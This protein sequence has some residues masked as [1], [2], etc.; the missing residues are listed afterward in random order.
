MNQNTFIYSDGPIH[1]QSGTL[2]QPNAS[3]FPNVQVGDV[4]PPL[5]AIGQVPIF[6][7]SD[8][9]GYDPCVRSTAS[10]LNSPPQD[11]TYQT[12]MIPEPTN[13]TI[14]RSQRVRVNLCELLFQ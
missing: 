3:Q 9:I 13:L 12:Q 10:N 5:S 1:D 7:T 14:D 2:F 8:I 4:N 6:H 11:D